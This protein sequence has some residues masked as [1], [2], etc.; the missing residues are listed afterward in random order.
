MK[1]KGKDFEL[2]LLQSQV[3][4]DVPDCPCC[5]DYKKYGLFIELRFWRDKNCSTYK[6][7][8]VSDTKELSIIDNLLQFTNAVVNNEIEYKD[9]I[10]ALYKYFVT[11]DIEEI[12]YDYE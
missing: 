6:I 2:E 7:K 10:S 5:S 3:T 4:V 12:T 8:E 11:L 9:V 1:Y